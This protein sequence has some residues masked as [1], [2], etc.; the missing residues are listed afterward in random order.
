MFIQEH[1]KQDSVTTLCRMLN[2]S[3]SGYYA[4]Q[5]HRP[6][7][8][9]EM[10][11]RI[12]P[13]IIQ[14]HQ[15]SRQSYGSPRIMQALR[16]RGLWC[17]RKRIMRLMR[18]HSIRAKTKRRYKV[19]TRSTPAPQ[20]PDLVRR[21]FSAP[22]PNR[23]W[24]SDITYLWTRE[25]WAYVA[26]VLDLYARRIVGWELASRLTADL[27]TSALQRALEVRKPDVG[28]ILHSDRGSQYTSQEVKR[29]AEAYGIQQSMGATGSCYDNAVTESFFHTFK[30]EHTHFQSYDTR[31]EARSSIFEYI[32]VFYNRQR[33]HSANNYLAPTDYENLFVTT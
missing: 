21:V 3:R 11:E 5:Q 9:Q 30:T 2:V 25:G 4:W 15:Q 14:I 10:N 16:Q 28:L 12:V 23:I 1:R 13:Q 33:L 31:L 32:E 27:V 20:V 22:A 8:R 18:L 19:T 24:T 26:V 17:N 29:L 7:Q 6:S